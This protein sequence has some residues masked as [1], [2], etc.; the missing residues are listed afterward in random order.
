M[1]LLI[2]FDRKID[3]R[4]PPLVTLT[5][6]LANLLVF[7]FLQGDD[8][9]RLARAL[10]YYAGSGLAQVEVP[11]WRDY[12]RTEDPDHPLLDVRAD[13]ARLP[14][15]WYLELQLDPGFMQRLE[16]GAVVRP[17]EARY[18]G[19]LEKRGEFE[20]RL[21]E[22]ATFGYGLVPAEPTLQGLFGHMFL[23]AGVVHLLGNMFFLVAVGFL[24][25]ATLGRVAFLGCYLAAGLIAGGFDLVFS[26]Q[27]L[28]PGIGASGAIAGL[29]GMYAVLYWTRR[30]RFF[31]FFVAYFDYVAM[32]AIALLPL[33]LLNEGVQLM[34][35]EESNINYLA[36][37]GG[38]CGGALLGL[39]ARRWLPSFS[40]EAVEAADRSAERERRLDEAQALCERLEYRK[41]R[42]LLRRLHQEAPDDRR[43]LF[44]LH[45][46]SRLEPASEEYHR[47]SHRILALEGRDPATHRLVLE[48]FGDYLQRARPG[49]RLNARIACALL[50]RFMDG[51]NLAEAERMAGAVLRKSWRCGDLERVLDRLG[52]LMT[53]AGHPKRGRRYRSLARELGRGVPEAV[54]GSGAAQA[55]D[56]A[57][58]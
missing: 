45:Q 27:R 2:P 6:V 22:V 7:V 19:W 28:A 41:A 55:A 15:L 8:D 13:P 54:P 9:E 18:A 16:A 50:E 4:R 43:A 36:H 35:D 20:R 30:V 37:L 23:H 10:S 46:C 47:L 3:W 58:E 33:W 38:L 11:A 34:V 31:Y 56:G 29:M 57:Q 25:E 53:D 14:P 42:P 44:Y 12:L 51:G 24:V 49:P 26:A 5:L 21:S 48:T 39:M 40:L 17:G 32:P 1:L 52:Q